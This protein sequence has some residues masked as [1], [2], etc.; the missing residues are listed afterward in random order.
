MKEQV[1]WQGR[2]TFKDILYTV[3]QR[4]PKMNSLIGT[5]VMNAYT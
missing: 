3:S 2:F 1:K 4:N 5:K